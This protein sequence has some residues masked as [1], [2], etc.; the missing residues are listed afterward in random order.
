MKDDVGIIIISFDTPQF[1]SEL[2]IVFVRGH[3]PSVKILINSNLRDQKSIDKII[4]MG[5]H[6]LVFKM[7]EDPKQILNAVKA[8]NENESYFI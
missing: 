2:N 4:K 3:S 1:L 7:D 5:V 8:L 6:G